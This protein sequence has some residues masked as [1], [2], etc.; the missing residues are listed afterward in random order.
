MAQCTATSKRT[1]ERC[2]AQAVTGSS[3]C[4][5]HGA[6]GGRPI[7]HGRYSKH[8]PKRLARN[9]KALI[10][11]PDLLQAQ[12]HL[13]LLETLLGERLA[14]LGDTSQAE[15]WGQAIDAYRE[16]RSAMSAGK[17][18]ETMN[19]L[20][21]LG[22]ILENGHGQAKAESDIRALIQEA[23]PVRRV[24]LQRLYAEETAVTAK[25][26]QALLAAV[27]DAINR[28]VDDPEAKRRVGEELL[29]LAG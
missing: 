24:E 1:G 8:L 25:Q 11:D 10:Q 28:F 27:L 18:D 22:A 23:V 6:S 13:A 7:K 9:Y 5:T 4:R 2:K 29:R 14:K 17:A 21:L 3:V 26:V 12:E 19:G 16:T 15:L 20:E